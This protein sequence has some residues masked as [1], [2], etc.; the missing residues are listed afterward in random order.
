V[1]AHE[2]DV[3]DFV[4]WA[5]KL[6]NIK[7]PAP[8]IILTRNNIGAKTGSFSITDRI[9]HVQIAGRLTADVYRTIFHE[10]VH[11]RQ[12]HLGMV[13]ASKSYPG[14]AIEALADMMAGKYVKLYG[15]LHPEIYLS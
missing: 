10:L 3:V 1:R 11:Y 6:L 13:T 7:N 9:I 4:N 8:K 14:S 2:F 15:K 5:I 12:S